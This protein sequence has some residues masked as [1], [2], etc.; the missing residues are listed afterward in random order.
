MLSERE[1]QYPLFGKKTRI[2]KKLIVPTA[3]QIA[4]FLSKISWKCSH[5]SNLIQGGGAQTVQIVR[6]A[7]TT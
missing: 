4:A 3:L 6:Q 5:Q 1:Y 2:I 7:T